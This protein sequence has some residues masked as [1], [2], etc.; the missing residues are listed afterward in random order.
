MP[1]WRSG[2]RGDFSQTGVELSSLEVVD[3]RGLVPGSTRELVDLLTNNRLQT[4]DLA[5]SH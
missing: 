4:K 5:V 2:K 1:E 3:S